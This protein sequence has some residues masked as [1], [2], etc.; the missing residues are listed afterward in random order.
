MAELCYLLTLNVLHE[1]YGF[2]VLIS[3]EVKHLVTALRLYRM[4]DVEEKAFWNAKER[5]NL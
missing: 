1:R 5:L 3:Y 2:S 4:R